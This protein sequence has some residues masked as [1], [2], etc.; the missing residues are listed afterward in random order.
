MA[1]HRVL[2]A[3]LE[4]YV[5]VLTSRPEQDHFRLTLVDGFAG[6]GR[7]LDERTNEERPGSPLIMLEAM[8]AAHAIAQERRSKP[9]KLDV[10]YFFVE[11]RRDSF[12][13]LSKTLKDSQYSSEI[14]NSITLLQGDFDNFVPAILEDI[15]KRGTAGRSIFVLD[16]CGYTD[17][18]LGTIRN[19]LANLDN[20]EVILT[21]ATDFLI[22]YL[23]ED[24]QTQRILEKT[25]IS[26][27]ATAIASAKQYREWRRIIQFA[28][29]REI[30][31]KTRAKYYT[32]FFI[33]S[34]ESKR[35]LWLVH[36]SGH[37]RARDV[38]VGLHWKEC[39]DFAHY[40]RSG[41]RML[42]YDP[43]KDDEWSKQKMLPGF[44]FDDTALVASQEELFEQLPAK[45]HQMKDGVVFNELFAGVTND[46]PVTAEI[47][48]GV[49][50]D[51]ANEGFIRIVSRK[52]VNRRRGVQHGSDIL[53][54]SR[55]L[56]FI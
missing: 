45:I 10:R 36:L 42:G 38:M 52:G 22:S 37:F 32:P 50:S 1:K 33:R 46:C 35:D 51:L 49:V 6:G 55:Q 28:L 14:G 7:Y 53:I 25:G 4:R 56:R 40:G 26:L 20:S 15:R 31:E 2:R 27:P 9:F 5:S 48:K 34:T 41:L 19:I 21:F 30:P 16:Q 24:E 29:H 17:V 44:Y 39:T 12:E 54:P 43:T 47:M 11:K 23:T 3:Y 18:P 8:R 13:F